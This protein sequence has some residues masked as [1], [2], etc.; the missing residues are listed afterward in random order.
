MESV[1]LRIPVQGIPSTELNDDVLGNRDL[2]PFKKGCKEC[3]L[4]HHQVW[5]L[6]PVW[7][8][9]MHDMGRDSCVGSPF[10]SC[11]LPVY[12]TRPLN[13]AS[14]WDLGSARFISEMTFRT[15][16]RNSPKEEKGSNNSTHLVLSFLRPRVGFSIPLLFSFPLLVLLLFLFIERA[17]VLFSGGRQ[18]TDSSRA[19]LPSKVLL[20]IY[21]LPPSQMVKRRRKAPKFFL[22]FRLTISK[23]IRNECVCG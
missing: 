13:H 9:E 20:V 11:C 15:C 5:I 10:F 22:H 19:W 2:V 7:Q 4:A 16:A 12:V 3:W 14:A 8:A 17:L 18:F 21:R 23:P 6:F 1:S